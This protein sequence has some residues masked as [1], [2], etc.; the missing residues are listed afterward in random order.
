MDQFSDMILVS[1]ILR[2]F[3][4][5]TKTGTTL[6]AQETENR[7]GNLGQTEVSTRFLPAELV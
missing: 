4:G 7:V 1:W 5:R 3:T 2:S 6:V